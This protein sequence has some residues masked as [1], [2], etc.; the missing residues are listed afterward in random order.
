METSSDARFEDSRDGFDRFV[1][2]EEGGPELW[3]EGVGGVA[4]YQETGVVG[5]EGEEVRE[6]GGCGEGGVG[7]V[8][9]AG[10][11]GGGGEGLEGCLEGLGEIECS[12]E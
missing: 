12:S 11:A 8:V 1:G 7:F 2:V 6:T 5:E 9:Y 4:A 10:D 3:D